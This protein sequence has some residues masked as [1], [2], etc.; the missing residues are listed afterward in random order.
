MAYSHVPSIPL[1]AV[2][3][4][5]VTLPI[6]TPQFSPYVPETIVMAGSAG[7][8]ASVPPTE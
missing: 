8:P 1:Q 2:V 6:G 3:S 5:V 7:R 4:W